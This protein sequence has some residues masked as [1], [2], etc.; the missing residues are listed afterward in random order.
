MSLTFLDIGGSTGGAVQPAGLDCG[1]VLAVEIK[2]IRFD[3]GEVP[4]VLFSL[5][6]WT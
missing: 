3:C 5:L 6:V 1:D 4:A 2:H